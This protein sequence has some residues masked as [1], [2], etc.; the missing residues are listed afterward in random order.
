MIQK[1]LEVK[2]KNG[3]TPM[4]MQPL[5]HL[6]GT[7]EADI[8]LLRGEKSINVKSILGLLSLGVKEQETVVISAS[9][10]DEKE[11]IEAIENYLAGKK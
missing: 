10:T 4:N 7:F 11:A 6:A 3:L 8:F 2:V 1:T 5:V 9:G